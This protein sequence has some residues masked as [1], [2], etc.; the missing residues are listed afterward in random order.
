[1]GTMSA[2]GLQ[3]LLPI[4]L[5]TFAD[6]GLAFDSNDR[7][8]WRFAQEHGMVLLTDN[9]N[10]SG[11]DSLEQTIREE[12]RQDSLPVLT[13]GSVER[14]VEKEYRERCAFR[15]I[16]I[17]LDLESYLGAARLYIH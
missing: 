11:A 10:M 15:L 12:S 4:G 1:M 9:R 7:T 8:V 6:V 14:I 17:I 5:T 16:E 2:E 13:I 3:G